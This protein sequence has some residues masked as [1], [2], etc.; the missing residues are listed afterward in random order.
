MKNSNINIREQRR[1][2]VAKVHTY[3]H[4]QHAL[5]DPGS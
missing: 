2:N 5:T 1:Q 4:V 3:D